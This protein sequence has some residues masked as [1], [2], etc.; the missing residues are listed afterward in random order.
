MLTTKFLVSLEDKDGIESLQTEM[1][2]SGVTLARKFTS[3]LNTYL[4]ASTTTTTTKPS[5]PPPPSPS[6]HS[7]EVD[8]NRLEQ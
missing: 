1:S 2:D 3:V 8:T 7:I 6:P 4:N 5:S